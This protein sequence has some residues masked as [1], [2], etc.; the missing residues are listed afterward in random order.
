MKAAHS[1]CSSNFT[2]NRRSSLEK[3]EFL[4]LQR[5]AKDKWDRGEAGRQKAREPMASGE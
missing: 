3:G 1:P 4:A 2:L 5:A